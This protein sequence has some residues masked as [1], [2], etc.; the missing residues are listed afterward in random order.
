MLAV[1]PVN[2]SVGVG[3]FKTPAVRVAA[4]VPVV[5]KDCTGTCVVEGVPEISANAG[6]LNC[7]TPL[8]LIELTHWCDIALTASTP[9]NALVVGLGN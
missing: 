9:P 7:G 5:V 3:T 4:P 1:A 2:G 8:V 6:W